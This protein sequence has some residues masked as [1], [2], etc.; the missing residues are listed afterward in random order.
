MVVAFGTLDRQG[1]KIVRDDLTRVLQ[2]VMTNVRCVQLVLIGIVV[3][4]QQEARCSEKF[5]DLRRKVLGR[6]P[7]DQLVARQL[8]GE[9]AVESFVIVERTNHI[10]SVT[11]AAFKWFDDGKVIVLTVDIDVAGPVEPASTPSLAKMF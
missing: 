9:E 4:A 5:H 6:T 7:I 2:D 8:L 10:V 11:P 1:E 3:R